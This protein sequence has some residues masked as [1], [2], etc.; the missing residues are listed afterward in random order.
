MKKKGCSLFEEMLM[1]TSYR[2]CIGRHTY[3]TSL[4]GEMAQHYYDKLSD[5][6]LE[7]T[8][9][10]IRSEIM[11]HLEFLPFKFRIQRWYEAD[12]FNPIK[13][14]MT[15]LKD[16]KIDSYDEFIKVCNLEYDVNHNTFTFEKKEP[17]LK[18]YFSVSDI[19]DLLPWENLAACFDKKNHKMVTLEY[20]DGKT[21]TH[22]CFQSWTR[23]TVPMED[24]PGYVRSAEWGWEPVWIDVDD[25]IKTGDNHRYIN[26]EY[27]KE[28]K[29][30]GED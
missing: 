11:Y 5:E 10:D 12:E 3:V 9:K 20:D 18:S 23:K 6:R 8:A 14:L 15:F 17:T 2:Y 26:E 16:Y 19:E 27:I 21:E 4:A 24:K 13:V 25:Y 28:I 30:K 29:E 22:E 7:F 1:W